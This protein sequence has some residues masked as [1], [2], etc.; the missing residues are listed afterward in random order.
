MPTLWR[1]DDRHPASHCDRSFAVQLL[2]F[3]V[4][5][6]PARISKAP[7]A[8]RR[9]RGSYVHSLTYFAK[10]TADGQLAQALTPCSPGAEFCECMPYPTSPTYGRAVPNQLQ[11]PIGARPPQTPAASF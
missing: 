10:R 3:L 4:K 9:T 6:R 5:R 11:T 8:R 1:P 7:S 2:R